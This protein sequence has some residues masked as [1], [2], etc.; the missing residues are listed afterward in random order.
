MV[1]GVRVHR[2]AWQKGQSRQN[3]SFNYL[4][5]RRDTARV[6]IQGDG[7]SLIDAVL[8]LSCLWIWDSGADD[9]SMPKQM[10]MCLDMELTPQ[11][12]TA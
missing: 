4:I 2:V 5:H 11:Q 12:Q 7:G 9:V 1:F 8:M 10:N 6:V 3:K